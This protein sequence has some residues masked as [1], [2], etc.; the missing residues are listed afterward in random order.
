MVY[1]YRYFLGTADNVGNS[2]EVSVG[3]ISGT[4]LLLGESSLM[5]KTSALMVLTIKKDACRTKRRI[6]PIRTKI[7][8]G[9]RRGRV[10]WVEGNSR[11]KD[12]GNLVW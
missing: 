5:I 6:C 7:E 9:T 10:G 4:C 3:S 11:Y 2:I 1:G 8:V 12:K